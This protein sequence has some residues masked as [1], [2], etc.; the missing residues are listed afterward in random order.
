MLYSLRKQST[1][2]GRAGVIERP[3]RQVV[4]PVRVCGMPVA[5]YTRF[6]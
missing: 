2:C 6:E 4:C 1:Q 5:W 3:S